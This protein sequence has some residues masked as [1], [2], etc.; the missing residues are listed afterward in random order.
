MT[1]KIAFR[2]N[3]GMGT[4][5]V[6]ANFVQYFY[7]KFCENISIDIFGHADPKVNSMIFSG[8]NCYDGLFNADEWRDDLVN[9][10]DIVIVLDLWP[11]VIKCDISDEEGELYKIVQGWLKFKSENNNERYFKWIRESKPYAY[12]YMLARGMTIIN[13]LDIN[14]DFEIGD[15]YILNIKQPTLECQHKI[16]SRFGLTLG[17]YITIQRGANP[18]LKFPDLP[19]LW[20]VSYYNELILGLKKMF[21]EYKIVQ[22]GQKT[23]TAKKLENT[24]IDLLDKTNSEELITVLKNGYLHFDSECGMVHLRKALHGGPSV[25]FFGPTDPRIFGYTGNLNLRSEFCQGGCAE[26]TEHWERLCPAGFENSKCMNEL[27]P[28]YVLD[29]LEDFIADKDNECHSVIFS[30]NEKLLKDDRI[31]L[32]QEWVDGWLN[33]QKVF[34]YSFVEEKLQD[35]RFQKFVG[36]DEK[37]LLLPLEESPVYKYLKGDKSDYYED[38]AFRKRFLDDNPHSEQRMLKLIKNIENNGFDNSNYIVIDS[39]NHIMDGY[40]RASYLLYKYGGHKKITVIRL[41]GDW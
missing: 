20:P 30:G 14:N 39:D 6:R 10:Y 41:Y 28:R 22:I 24:D 8:N 29:K 1:V 34:A 35:L 21:P 15:E 2:I 36:G 27:K 33:K 23:E 3:G 31:K 7:N 4:V 17:R 12:K 11:N 40:H 9:S 16:L 37:W 13:S 19:K 18:K 32:N 5:L 26:I 25:V 38:L